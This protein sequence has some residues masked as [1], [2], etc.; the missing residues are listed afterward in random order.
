MFLVIISNRKQLLLPNYKVTI[1]VEI[2][3]NWAG[4][5][6]HKIVYDSLSIY[7]QFIA[8]FWSVVRFYSFKWKNLSN[9]SLSHYLLQQGCYYVFDPL[10]C[11]DMIMMES[12]C[13]LEYILFG[14]PPLYL[15]EFK[16][17]QKEWFISTSKQ[18]FSLATDK[19][20]LNRQVSC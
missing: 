12:I 6:I 14:K 20:T 18:I 8:F 9:M 1:S 7:H 17:V 11:E 2:K 3:N 16:V 4:S 10:T 13:F 15:N 5:C 19:K